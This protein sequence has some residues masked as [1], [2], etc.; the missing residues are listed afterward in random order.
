MFTPNCNA[1]AALQLAE[2]TTHGLVPVPAHATVLEEDM[3]QPFVCKGSPKHILSDRGLKI[4]LAIPFAPNLD[5]K[6]NPQQTQLSE[7][8]HYHP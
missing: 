6:D 2:E 3:K 4:E 5:S 1:L 7:V 8:E